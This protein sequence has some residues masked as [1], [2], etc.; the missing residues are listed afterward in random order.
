MYG[1]IYITTNHVNGKKYIGQKKYIKGWEDYLGSGIALNNAIKKYGKENFSRE[2]I[3]VCDSKE[4]LDIREIYWINYYNATGSKDFYNIAKGGNGGDTTIGY[5]KDQKENLR[6][7]KS[8]SLKGINTGGNNN[9]AKPV[10][11]LNNMKIYPSAA[12]AD[13]AYGLRLGTV[14]RACNEN[15]NLRTAGYDQNTGERLLWEFYYSD[16]E[17]TYV[18]FVRE[19]STKKIYCFENDKIYNSSVEASK[20]LGIDSGLI[21]L[22]CNHHLKST[23]DKH[24]LYY[25][26]YQE[27]SEDEL[28][29]LRDAARP[30]AGKRNPFYGKHHSQET[31]KLIGEKNK[32]IPKRF[33][34]NNDKS[35]P[36]L[37]IDT[38]KIYYSTREAERETGV[39]HSSI[40]KCCKGIQKSAGGYT[41]KYAI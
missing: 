40:T 7:K 32:L 17:Y 14:A 11:C 29:P 30:R 22:C 16:K 34:K 5:S 21:R 38:N 15:E 20:E 13:R 37:C 4:S 31:K 33:G 3:E 1:F 26:E 28:K 9:Q 41:W 39:D 8:K 19:Y 25:E 6:I 2:I 10:I 24:F 27:M 18:P 36:I 23:H 35:I 12:D